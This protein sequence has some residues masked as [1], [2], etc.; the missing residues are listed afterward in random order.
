MK[1]FFAV[2]LTV[3]M[4]FSLMSFGASAYVINKD[5]AEIDAGVIFGSTAVYF[6]DATV[7]EGKSVTVDII[8]SNNDFGI[9][10]IDISVDFPAGVDIETV[11]NGEMGTASYADGVISVVSETVMEGNGVIAK[12]TFVADQAGEYEINLAANA[13][14]G[15]STVAVNGST[16]KLTVTE[17]AEETVVGDVDGDGD[18]DGT[19]LAILKLN[20]AGAGNAVTDGADMNGDGNVNASDLAL[21]KLKL[22]GAA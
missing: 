6:E 17:S 18:C 16:C 2:I 20:L 9:T 8:L 1:K 21:L 3:A 4:L 22:A 5:D 12:V 7:E 11:A 13:Q 14:N 15:D 10:D 19:D